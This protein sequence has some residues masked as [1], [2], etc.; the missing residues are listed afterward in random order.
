MPFRP[1]CTYHKLVLQMY[2]SLSSEGQAFQACLHP[3]SNGPL[4]RLCFLHQLFVVRF[5]QIVVECHFGMVPWSKQDCALCCRPEQ[6]TAKPLCSI[7]TSHLSLCARYGICAVSLS[8]N[9][10]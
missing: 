5:V 6:C 3:P 8:V 1:A 9:D 10:T 7:Q 4:I 2:A